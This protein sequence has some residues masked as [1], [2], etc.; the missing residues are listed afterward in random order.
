ME[1]A[2]IDE[3]PSSFGEDEES[4]EGFVAS[5]GNYD[6]EKEVSSNK[7]AKVL[8]A[9]DDVGVPGEMG[10]DDARGFD[11][12]FSRFDQLRQ[13]ES[14]DGNESGDGAG[15]EG[16]DKGGDEGSDRADDR[17]S[18][19]EAQVGAG[20]FVDIQKDVLSKGEV[21]IEVSGAGKDVSEKG[22]LNKIEDPEV[23]GSLVKLG[24]GPVVADSDPSPQQSNDEV[25]GDK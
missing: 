5:P 23:R 24:S 20:Q 17:V 21:V 25:L 9:D 16:T 13:K 18:E 7:G 12:K 14:G 15:D 19:S 10:Y 22:K 1:G 8:G 3:S 2:G 11:F 6:D 4:L